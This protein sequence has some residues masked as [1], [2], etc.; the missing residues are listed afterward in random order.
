MARPRKFEGERLDHV[1]SLLKQHG[2]TKTRDILATPLKRFGKTT[3][4]NKLRDVKMFPEPTKVSLLCLCTI[5]KV[6]GL[7]FARGRKSP[8]KSRD[9][10]RYVAKLV[11]QNG[12]M[13]TVEIL[14]GKNRDKTL[15]PTPV[16]VSIPHVCHIAH[17]QG[18]TLQRGR[19]A[20]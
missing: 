4:V 20:A 17:K 1:V 18:V 3:G 9:Q 15:F 10:K 11:R 8:I 7:K 5:A 6:H 16:T 13:G 19:R 2:A 14:A 12:A